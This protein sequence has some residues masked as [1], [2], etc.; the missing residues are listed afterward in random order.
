MF[1]S[2]V[3][4]G[5]LRGVQADCLIYITFDRVKS[6]K[7]DWVTSGLVYKA[8]EAA[9]KSVIVMCVCMCVFGSW[10]DSFRV[11]MLSSIS[12]L[13][14]L[15]SSD[16]VLN[17]H[18]QGIDILEPLKIRLANLRQQIRRVRRQA[19][20][21][22]GELWVE[23]LEA[24][25]VTDEGFVRRRNLLPLQHGPVDCFEEVMIDN[26]LKASLATPKSLSRILVQE[27][28]EHF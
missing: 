12:W 17:R 6:G 24:E 25:I 7:E 3:S 26:I 19:R 9:Y 15:I 16:L 10:N 27:F 11:S 8:H 20:R 2:S 5:F 1:N 22:V 18:Q 28:L 14:F 23:I 21:L 13:H 4:L